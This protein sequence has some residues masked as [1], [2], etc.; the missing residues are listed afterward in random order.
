MAK[1]SINPKLDEFLRNAKKWGEEMGAAG[2]R[3]GLPP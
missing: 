2:D 3:S 1:N